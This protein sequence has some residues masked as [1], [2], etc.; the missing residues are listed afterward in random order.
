LIALYS[1]GLSTILFIIK[2]TKEK[3]SLISV[4]LETILAAISHT[5][6][7]LS[8]CIVQ[9]EKGEEGNVKMTPV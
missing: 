2:S 4:V 7:K 3:Q 5:D 9:G 8:L 1:S 6:L